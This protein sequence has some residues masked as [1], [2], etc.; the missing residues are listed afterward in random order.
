MRILL[1]LSLLIAVGAHGQAIFAHNDYAKARPFYNAFEL[2]TSFIEVD[3][4]LRDG[5]LLVAHTR[6]EI[7]PAKTLES[8]YLLPLSKNIDKL[9]SLTLMI[10]LKTEGAPTMTALV[11]TLEK[12]PQLTSHPT[13]FIAVSGSYPPP[14]EWSDYPSFISFDGRPGIEYTPEQL[15]RIVLISTSFGSVS[16]WKG[17]GDIPADDA[18]KIKKIIAD[19]HKL[20]RGIR[21]WGSPDFENAWGKFIQVGVDVLNSDNI[22]G[23]SKY[24]SDKN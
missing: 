14:A 1:A 20:G 9:Y 22:E 3:I 13:L 10:D 23:L 6:S 18:A 5:N 15:Q 17:K 4:F 19:A 16:N 12:F 21:F 2:K 8:M 11:K 7:D 24:L